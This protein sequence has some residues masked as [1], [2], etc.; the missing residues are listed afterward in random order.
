MQSGI[1]LL[2]TEML[3][4]KANEGYINNSARREHSALKSIL[5]Y[6]YRSPEKKNK[7]AEQHFASCETHVT[8][9]LP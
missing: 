2:D 7:S 9:C 1:A 8:I 3:P 4:S 5:H 6:S